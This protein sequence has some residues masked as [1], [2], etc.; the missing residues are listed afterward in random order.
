[1]DG[2]LEELKSDAPPEGWSDLE[3]TMRA[4]ELMAYTE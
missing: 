1:V 4:L 2:F 3:L